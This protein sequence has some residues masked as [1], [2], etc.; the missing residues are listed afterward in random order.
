MREEGNDFGQSPNVLLRVFRA[1]WPQLAQ[2]QMPLLP[3]EM[4]PFSDNVIAIEHVGV[5]S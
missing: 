5:M 4:H 2:N 1:F 3:G